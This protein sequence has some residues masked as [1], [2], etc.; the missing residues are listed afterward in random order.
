MRSSRGEERRN[1]W[2][3][4]SRSARW[5]RAGTSQRDVPSFTEVTN[6]NG[7]WLSTA[8]GTEVTL[9]ALASGRQGSETL[10]WFPQ[11]THNNRLVRSQVDLWWLR[12]VLIYHL[13]V[14]ESVRKPWK[15]L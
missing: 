6:S 7:D 13:G 5:T 12:C 9:D 3:I 14:R 2:L 11:H 10:I 1:A 15:R 8:H 4:A